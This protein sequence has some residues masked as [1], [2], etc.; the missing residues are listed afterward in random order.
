MVVVSKSEGE[1]EGEG[2]AL[3]FEERRGV[4][5]TLRGGFGVLLSRRSRRV[6]VVLVVR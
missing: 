5:E 4:L 6:K 3:V 2:G 1:G